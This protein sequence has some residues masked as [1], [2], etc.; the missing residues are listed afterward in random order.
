[1]QSANPGRGSYQPGDAAADLYRISM[2]ELILYFM[3]AVVIWNYLYFGGRNN[4]GQENSDNYLRE[5]HNT[6]FTEIQSC[7]CLN[8][9]QIEKPQNLKLF[10]PKA[11][12]EGYRRG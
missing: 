12:P 11:L 9:S 5:E 2:K 6:S 3:M 10:W 7:D 8:I 1:M 4:Y